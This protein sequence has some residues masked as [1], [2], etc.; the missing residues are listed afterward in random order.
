MLLFLF[1][2]ALTLPLLVL[3]IFA[4][5]R[6]A[7]LE[8]AETERRVLYIA[9]GLAADVDRELERA[10]IT[11]ETLATASSITNRD[12]AAFHDQAGRAIRR[13]RAGILLIDPQFQ[14]LVNTRAPFGTILPPTSDIATAKKVL[15]SKKPEIS[16]LF[17]GV[18][19]RGPV[20]NVEVP[21][22]DGE[23]ISFILIMALDATRFE[24]LLKSQRLE[25]QWITGITDKNNVIVARSERHSEFVGKSVPPEIMRDVQAN[26]SVVRTKTVAGEDVLRATARS[27]LTG[28]MVSATIPVSYLEAPR[29]RGLFFS[30]AMTA[31]ALALGS[32]LAYVFGGFMSRPLDATAKAAV[33]V[34]EGKL[35]EP[36]R[37]PLVEANTVTS[38]LS[39]ASRELRIRQDR[40]EFLM[41]ELAH[42]SKNQLAVIQGMITQT[43]RRAGSVDEFVRQIGQRIQGLAQSQDLMLRENW[44]GARLTELVHAHIELFGADGR[45]HVEGPDLFLSANAVQNIGFALHELA[46]NASKHGALSRPEGKVIVRWRHL[47][48][49]GRLQLDWIESG[50]PPVQPPQR[51]GFGHLVLTELVPATL[52][53][54]AKLDFLPEGVHWHLD[55]PESGA[56]ISAPAKS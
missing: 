30:A 11:L 23:T 3:A 42:R 14:M 33:A 39:A 10:T 13:D 44:H 8:Q 29:Q 34:G 4:L 53:G 38:A 18:I 41:R 51:Q 48:P 25:P 20:V 43:A 2:V 45:A 28:W 1:A 37:T 9:Q 36:L 24:E 22:F 17:M 26:E 46:T 52:Q 5:N 54:K 31:L 19:S 49:E 35:V 40:T 16:D 21:V 15:A 47:E 7:G 32:A 55:I 27:K 56:V 6:M 12:L 50:G